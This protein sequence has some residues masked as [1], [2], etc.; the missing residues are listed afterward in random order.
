MDEEKEGE[1]EPVKD[2]SVKASV[3]TGRGEGP[4][5]VEGDLSEEDWDGEVSEGVGGERGWETKE[6]AEDSEEDEKG[7]VEVPDG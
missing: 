6:E 2:E 1:L 7:L 5:L 3:I 4:R